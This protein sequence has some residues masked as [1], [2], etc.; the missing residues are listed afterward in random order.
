ML[1]YFTTRTMPT[2]TF[3]VHR[4]LYT[5]PPGKKGGTGTLLTKV[6]NAEKKKTLQAVSNSFDTV[7]KDSKRKQVEL[8]ANEKHVKMW[9]NKL[10]SLG[11]NLGEVQCRIMYS[12]TGCPEQEFHRDYDP[13]LT[14]ENTPR[15]ALLAIQNETPIHLVDEHRNK[16]YTVTLNRGDCVVFD[17]RMIHA[18]AAFDK[19]NIR[20]HAYLNLSP[21]NTPENKV[22]RLSEDETQKMREMER[23]VYDDACVE[24]PVTTEPPAINLK[25]VVKR[26]TAE[27]VEQNKV[28]VQMETKRNSLRQRVVGLRKKLKRAQDDFSKSEARLKDCEDSLK[29][30][31]KR[32]KTLDEKMGYVKQFDDIQ[33]RMSDLEKEKAT[34]FSQISIDF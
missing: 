15:V 16:M 21:D 14:N 24:E 23:K 26:L 27:L 12:E 18:G 13:A 28:V 7:E 17:G 20:V 8:N 22:W 11:E 19:D 2:P 33:K 29:Q 9:L 3:K 10:A 4:K 30:S 1:R 5:W 34:L 25:E 6:H 32:R 31:M